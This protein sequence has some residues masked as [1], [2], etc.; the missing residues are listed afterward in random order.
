MRE[1][2][3]YTVFAPN[4]AAFAQIKDEQ[5]VG[6]FEAYY[7]MSKLV[8]YQIVLGL[9]RT[10]DLLDRIFLKTLEGQRLT[11]ESS[12]TGERDTETLEDGT[13]VHGYVERDTVTTTLLESIKVD[14][15]VSYEAT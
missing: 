13:D 7:N 10:T 3:A 15:R 14:A 1:P 4:D 2:G 8:K 6:L 5:L 12:A 9:Y 11:I